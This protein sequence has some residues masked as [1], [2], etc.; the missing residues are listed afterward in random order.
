MRWLMCLAMAT[1]C[2]RSADNVI[3]ED[4]A[5]PSGD[6]RLGGTAPDLADTPDLLSAGD[7]DPAGD[8][9]D[10]TL[11]MVA[12]PD[13]SGDMLTVA[14]DMIITA[15]DA[16]CTLGDPDHCGSCTTV[17]PPGTDSQGTQRTC[18]DATASATCDITCT[19]EFYDL[20]GKT[21][22]GCE[23]QDL[24]VQDTTTTA[25]VVTLGDAFSSDLGVT[26][27][28]VTVESQI[29][30]D[31]RAHDS[32]PTSRPNGRPDWYKLLVMGNGD[33]KHTV[34]A[35]LDIHG[36]PSD[37]IF[38]LCISDKG[39]STFSATY[40]CQTLNPTTAY[41]CVQLP[42]DSSE[43]GTYYVRVQRIS[44]TWTAMHYS[45]WMAH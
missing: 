44:G 7:M 43:A 33:G 6:M 37:D 8:A 39:T 26:S 28:P 30:G 4:G 34:G 24:P 25:V 41:N 31:S 29:Y 2:T 16:S 36:F 38:E 27:N 32:A 23:A 9:A 35:C 3:G 40:G 21:S 10:P 14:G 17:C 19:G 11:D 15:P 13:S 1:G 20:D 22:T 12:T 5:T 42:V 18:S 45:L